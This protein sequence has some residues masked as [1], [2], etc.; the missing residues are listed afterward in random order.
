MIHTTI[1]IEGFYFWGGGITY[2][3]DKKFKEVI[4][5]AMKKLKMFKD[6]KE[7]QFGVLE[8]KAKTL[9]FYFHPSQTVIKTADKDVNDKVVKTII[10]FLNNSTLPVTLIKTKDFTKKQ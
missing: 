8:L 5:N 4:R 3:N 10:E 7:S 9:D 2:E 1:F 6:L